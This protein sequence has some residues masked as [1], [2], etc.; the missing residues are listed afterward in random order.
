MLAALLLAAGFY[1]SAAALASALGGFW[2][3]ADRRSVRVDPGVF[4]F[5]PAAAGA[6][7][8]AALAAGLALLLL[9]RPTR[10]SPG[11][12]A[13]AIAL[14]EVPAGLC[15]T[16][17]AA[18]HKCSWLAW[19]LAV[20]ERSPWALASVPAFLALAAAAG[21]AAL[22]PLASR[23]RGAQ[24]SPGGAPR[25][26]VDRALLYAGLALAVATVAL[27]H[28]PPFNPSMA[29]VSV[30]TRF[31]LAW[32]GVLEERGLV[33]GLRETM[34]ALR[35]LYMLFIYAASR[36]APMEPAVLFDVALPMAGLLLLTLAT[37]WASARLGS[38]SPGLAALAAPLYWGPAFAY[39]GFQ[40][41]LLALPLGL[42]AY[43]LH[44]TGRTLASTLALLPLGLWHPWTLAYYAASAA[45]YSLAVESRPRR[46]LAP[47]AASAASLSA[48]YLLLHSTGSPGAIAWLARPA[49]PR[50]PSLGGVAF[51][52]QV[53]VWGTMARPEV[54][55]PAA[56]AAWRAA[57]ERRGLALAVPAAPL[58]LAL[59][60]RPASLYRMALMAPLPLLYAEAGPA[61]RALAPAALSS[62]LILLAGS[63]PRGP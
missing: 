19:R 2:L 8:A 1:L 7:G 17:Y 43:T 14:I 50:G 21:L 54:Q 56:L 20:L 15:F 61:A 47:L 9:A 62:W 32:L 49:E 63:P 27:P 36:L 5:H 31:N 16:V 45:Y 53:Y 10:P 11:I 6:A 46:A 55:A 60:M 3:S 26:G 39:G 12:L 13:A 35:P 59:L 29:V 18:S 40:T 23:A 25:G 28:L 48:L 44:A 51:A 37:Y 4:G 33:E 22:R 41:N 57:R 52:L 42:A 30:D 34:P 38:R 24:P 58:A